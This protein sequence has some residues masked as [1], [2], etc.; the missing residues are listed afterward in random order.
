MY[1][2]RPAAG[3]PGRGAPPSAVLVDQV[4]EDLG[5]VSQDALRLA[6]RAAPARN[7]LGEQ[8]Q[9]RLGQQQLLA[10]LVSGGPLP[11]P[12]EELHQGGI[13][14]EARLLELEP[15]VELG[16]ARPRVRCDRAEDAELA[17]REPEG[18]Q[19]LVVDPRELA[20]QDPR[21][22]RQTLAPHVARDAGQ[23]ALPGLHDL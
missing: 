3:A 1:M 20:A 5:V 2:Y 21:A 14:A 11:D 19:R 15:P 9:A 22:A 16:G 8:R 4:R 10:A 18:T 6:L 17:R 13:A 12:A 23:L 7:G